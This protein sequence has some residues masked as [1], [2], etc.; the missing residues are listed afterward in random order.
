MK[1]QDLI[2]SF[3][4]IG[5]FVFL[6]LTKSSYL[7]NV[8][9]TSRE[10]TILLVLSFI[11]FIHKKGYHSTS[12]LS[13]LFLIYLIKTLWITWPY[14]PENRLYIEVQKDKARFDPS[15]S[16]DLQFANK[17]VH[18][19]LPVLLVQPYFPDLLKFPPS[20]S[21]LEELNGS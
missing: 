6:Q 16:I 7:L 4:L 3:I 21:T 2:A 12:F 17:S 20:T 19:N 14:S 18:H 11:I 5:I 13:S 10:I 8:M 9:S 15:T 1:Q